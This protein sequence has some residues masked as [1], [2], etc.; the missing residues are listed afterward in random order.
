VEPCPLGVFLTRRRTGACVALQWDAPA[1]AYRC[2][3]LVVP[4]VVL[5]RVPLLGLGL[6]RPVARWM[7]RRWARRWIGVGLG[8][9]CSL[10]VARADDP[11]VG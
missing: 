2:G 6:W 5:D 3:A 1:G 7:L 8:C 11:R 10:E 9:D 4:D